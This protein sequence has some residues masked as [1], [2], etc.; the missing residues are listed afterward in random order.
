MNSLLGIPTNLINPC[1]WLEPFLLHQC[2]EGLGYL[3]VFFFCFYRVFPPGGRD[4]IVA[5]GAALGYLS[6]GDFDIALLLEPVQNGVEDGD[7]VLAVAA[8]LELR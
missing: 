8:G 6:Y 3:E 1:K 5:S 2:L 7:R 4:R